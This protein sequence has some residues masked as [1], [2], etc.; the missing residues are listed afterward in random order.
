MNTRFSANTVILL[1]IL[2]A[3]IAGGFLLISTVRSVTQP[4]VDAGSMLQKQF[5]ALTN[6]A[7][8]T[9]TIIP[10]P[11]TIIHEVVR[12]ARLETSAYSVEK[13]ITAET[14]QG[15]FA[16]L[17]GDKLL[18]V[19]HGQVIAGVDLSK[20]GDDDIVV[21][22]DGTVTVVLPPAEVFIAT[23]DNQKS[24]I[25]DRE[26]GVIGMNPHL[27]TDARRAAEH[28]ILNAA[29]ED[30]ILDRAQLNAEDIIRRLILGL[31]FKK[32]LFSEQPATAGS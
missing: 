16:F 13:I 23:L 12:L 21:A 28:E 25:Y 31:G 20:M 26:V 27:E 19:S 30:G 6:F 29:L 1:L 11:V 8:P 10:D 22:Q 7:N 5:D 4:I 9:P 15:P 32:V 3:V 2:V 17:F 14:R 18:L 24:Y